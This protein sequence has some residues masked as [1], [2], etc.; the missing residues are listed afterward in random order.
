M[1]DSLRNKTIYALDMVGLIAGN[2]HIGMLEQKIDELLQFITE[3]S[4]GEAIL[5]IDEVHQLISKPSVSGVADL[6]KPALARGLS[7]IAATTHDEFQKYI[8]KDQCPRATFLA[9]NY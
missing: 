7:L 1:P 9:C 2:T 4:K 5:F 8:M 6:L 3:T